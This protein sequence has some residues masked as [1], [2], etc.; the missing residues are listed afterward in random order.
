MVTDTAFHADTDSKILYVVHTNPTVLY[1]IDL[2]NGFSK[3]VDLSDVFFS[4]KNRSPCAFQV[5]ALDESSCVV[6]QRERGCMS[7]V[8]FGKSRVEETETETGLDVAK[9]KFSSKMGQKT[10]L[11]PWRRLVYPDEDRYDPKIPLYRATKTDRF[12]VAWNYQVDSTQPEFDGRINVFD[13]KNGK[14]FSLDIK[15]CLDY[16]SSTK[17]GEIKSVTALEN[18]NQIMVTMGEHFDTVCFEINVENDSA[19][20]VE[21]GDDLVGK[22]SVNGSRFKG[23]ANEYSEKDITIEKRTGKQRDNTNYYLNFMRTTNFRVFGR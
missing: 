21:I 3:K 14:V 20:L 11:D 8:D 7:V 2:E 12:V 15:A 10:T 13:Q 16:N 6:F 18:D 22:I 5:L 4:Y 23:V 9:V 19:T 1:R 17:V